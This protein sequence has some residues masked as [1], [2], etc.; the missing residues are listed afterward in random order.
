MTP[1]ILALKYRYAIMNHR[2]NNLMKSLL[3]RVLTL[4]TVLAFGTSPA[5]AATEITFSI[6]G[7][8]PVHVMR[9][10]EPNQPDIRIGY[11]QSTDLTHTTRQGP[12]IVDTVEDGII[13]YSVILQRVEGDHYRMDIAYD[14]ASADGRSEGIRNRSVINADVLKGIT[15]DEIQSRARA[16]AEAFSEV[17][18]EYFLKYKIDAE[19]QTS[20]TVFLTEIFQDLLRSLPRDGLSIIRR[21][22]DLTAN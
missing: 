7:M 10:K 19:V 22:D 6:S 11:V 16:H 9:F 5:F 20:L 15:T 17:V 4:Y 21:W 1:F 3:Q 18:F 13:Y 14:F 2:R 12:H 8:D